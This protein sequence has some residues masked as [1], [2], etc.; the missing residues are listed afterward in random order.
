MRHRLLTVEAE[1][2]NGQ[3]PASD[4]LLWP[5]IDYF[6][7][8]G[9]VFW[10][11]RGEYNRGCILYQNHRQAGQALDIFQRVKALMEQCGNTW[12]LGR[13]YGRMAYIYHKWPIQHCGWRFWTGGVFI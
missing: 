4:S 13:T 12:W 8:A 1:C 2:R 6:H 10:E 5:V 9:D 7:R 3:M 11:A